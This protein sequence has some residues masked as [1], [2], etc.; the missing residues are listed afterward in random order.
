MANDPK[1]QNDPPAD[2]PAEPDEETTFWAKF[3]ERLKAGV[4]GAIDE[5]LKEFRENSNSRTGRKT[6]PG[7]IA[8][9]MFGQEPSKK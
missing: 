9:F 5:K 4:G 8:D 6:L 2:P 7:F 1:T 3:D